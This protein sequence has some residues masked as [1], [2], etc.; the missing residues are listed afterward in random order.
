MPDAIH[1][2]VMHSMT[3][4]LY[5]NSRCSTEPTLPPA[6]ERTLG[7]LCFPSF[8]A[9]LRGI[10]SPSRSLGTRKVTGSAGQVM[11]QMDTRSL[12]SKLALLTLLIMPCGVAALPNPD[13]AAGAEGERSVDLSSEV[14]VPASPAARRR[15]D[16]AREA[17]Q[18]ECWVDAVG[19]VQKLL[20]DEVE[21]GF[22]GRSEGTAT[23]STLKVE[24]ARL[25]DLMPREAHKLY[26][27]QFGAIA[28]E[29]LDDAVTR[30]DHEA[31]ARLSATYFHTEAGCH[32]TMLLARDRLDCGRPREALAWLRRL[33]A[34]PSTARLCQPELAL[35]TTIS[36]IL[37]DKRGKAQ[38]VIER[39]G[40]DHPQAI[41]R[42]GDEQL[43]AAR[44]AD[45]VVRLLDQACGACLTSSETGTEWRM[46]RGDAARNAASDWN[47]QLGELS[48]LV[49]TVEDDFEEDGEENSSGLPALYPLAV[50]GE[51]LA[52]TPA[53]RLVAA[54]ANTGKRVWEYPRDW[55][56][57]TS[58]DTTGRRVI[59]IGGQ[60]GPQAQ[61]WQDAITGQVSSDGRHVY[62]VVGLAGS[63]GS[64]SARMI[65]NRAAQWRLGTT[66]PHNRLVAL[67]QRLQGAVAWTVGGADGE[68]EPGLAGV[69]FLGAP[70]CDGTKLYALAE[71]SGELALVAL[72]AD[73]GRL[74]WWQP[75]ARP[76]LPITRDWQ[77]RMVGATPSMAD[78]VIIC[79]TSAGV[80][81]A[82]E[83]L[84]G[85][86]LW[87]YRYP[88]TQNATG[89]VRRFPFGRVPQPAAKENTQGWVD[90]SA[91]IAE[92]RVLLTPVDSDELL[93]LDLLTG[94]A[95]W[96]WEGDA[97]L[98][99][100]CVH[101]DK[102][103]VVGEKEIVAL[104]L[105][106]GRTAWPDTSLALPPD[107]EPSSRGLRA[108][109]FYY[110]PIDQAAILKI[111]LADGQLVERIKTPTVPGNLLGLKNRLIWQTPEGVWQF[112]AAPAR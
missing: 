2:I 5:P 71:I 99:I 14:L 97:M 90:A 47:G 65:R 12:L 55:P 32:A 59:M 21:D 43:N 87:G 98:Y 28:Q 51:I 96:A 36:W 86:L 111:N 103:V 33:N 73:S 82:A 44:D 85:R 25:M 81:V 7:K 3:Y 15:L 8:E 91:T 79:P 48:W 68:D 112:T 74:K 107:A 92:G 63:Q 93:C 104:N 39:L 30:G 27:L 60:I 95:L 100:A 69:F 56:E 57:E 4:I 67:S 23:C 53:G 109:A 101:D 62:L 6:W 29:L 58:V 70:V 102:V 38:E 105:A 13:I 49:K 75:L 26:D 10:G 64:S 88:R 42:I 24:A 20:S 22:T 34:S 35:L 37:L 66:P 9:E 16:L 11:N 52:R 108:G 45:R 31:L 17:A 1:G 50:S 106:D 61:R 40:A 76:H 110:L 72:L 18:Q 19:A 46:F 41:V 54:E 84:T 77:R 83:A 94:K 78:G 89:Q 80:V